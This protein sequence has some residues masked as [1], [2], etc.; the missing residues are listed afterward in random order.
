MTLGYD[1]NGSDITR[2]ITNIEYCTFEIVL[3]VEL[4][5]IGRMVVYFLIKYS[6]LSR[7]FVIQLNPQ[8]LKQNLKE[9][10]DGILTF[11][12]GVKNLQST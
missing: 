12:D 4:V 10:N 6:S 7:V 8:S 11:L 5:K 9:F 2:H 1:A 3:L